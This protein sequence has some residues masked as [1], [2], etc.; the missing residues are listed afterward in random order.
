M[1]SIQGFSTKNPEE[2]KQ[3]LAQAGVKVKLPFTATDFQA[4]QDPLP[5]LWQD[6]EGNDFDPMGGQHS[7]T[8]E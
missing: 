1:P 2:M 4:E 3:K 6:S 5:G 7:I 8:I